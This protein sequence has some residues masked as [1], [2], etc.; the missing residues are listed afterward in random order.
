MK[1]VNLLRK[2]A[3]LILNHLKK[4][5]S[6]FVIAQKKRNYVQMNVLRKMIQENFKRLDELEKERE[7][8]IKRTYYKIVKR[9]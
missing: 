1:N 6:K 2:E 7:K 8:E 5:N 9:K 3:D 4:L